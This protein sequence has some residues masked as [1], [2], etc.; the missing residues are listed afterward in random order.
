MTARTTVQEAPAQGAGHAV[1]VTGKATVKTV[2]VIVGTVMFLVR[3][4][5]LPARIAW[6][7]RKLTSFA[8]AAYGAYRA[9]DTYRRAQDSK[10]AQA[11][12]AGHPVP[13][14]TTAP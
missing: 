2:G 7:T 14:S 13:G 6:K 4:V 10:R 12:V 1:A 9:Y 11:P 8:G 5:L 3:T